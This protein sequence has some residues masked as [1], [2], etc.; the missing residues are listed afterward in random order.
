MRLRRRPG[1]VA[2]EQGQRKQ[3]PN[4]RKRSDERDSRE[5][6]YPRVAAALLEHEPAQVQEGR[7]E[8]GEVHDHGGVGTDA[9]GKCQHL[10]SEPH[11]VVEDE[12]GAHALDADSREAHERRR[13]IHPRACER[14]HGERGD[15]YRVERADEA[16]GEVVREEGGADAVREDEQAKAKA[17]IPVPG[18]AMQTTNTRPK[19]RAGRQFAA[20]ASKRRARLEGDCRRSPD[21]RVPLGMRAAESV[22][23]L[24]HRGR[25][26][27]AA[28]AATA[29]EL[30]QQ[31]R[32]AF[33][34]GPDA[35]IR[36]LHKGRQLAPDAPLIGLDGKVMVMS[37]SAASI[38]DLNAA[39][40]DPTLRG[41]DNEDRIAA[42]RK[43]EAEALQ[44]A[45]LA[46]G[47]SKVWRSAQD[48]R[49]R[50]S[51][52]EAV[53]WQNFGTRPGTSTPHQFAAR[54]L[55]D[56]MATDPGVVVC[57]SQRRGLREEPSPK[58]NHNP[59]LKPSPQM[60]RAR[61][62]VVGTLGEMDPI[63]DRLKLSLQQ[64][65]GDL[66][67]YNTNHGM[68]IDM[69]L[70]TDDLVGFMPYPA[71]AETLLHELC[72]NWVGPHNKLFWTLFAQMRVEYL[73]EHFRLAASGV[74]IDGQTTAALAGIRADCE[75]PKAI[76]AA[77]L[78]GIAQEVGLP[79]AHELEEAV[80]EHLALVQRE[81][82][83]AL[84]GRV[85]G[86]GVPPGQAA[87]AAEISALTLSA[88][89]GAPLSAPLVDPRA[90]AAAAAEARARGAGAEARGQ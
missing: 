82:G 2:G 13:V 52:I 15:Q 40:A 6:E 44:P 55:L 36:L 20:T 24:V 83:G 19:K 79:M 72:H 76:A 1:H 69:K 63:D 64:Q 62:L 86:G 71:L 74:L 73:H 43:S 14:G 21:T 42:I 66:L 31:A 87:P 78:R 45:A 53:G 32:T 5:Q 33:A 41:F 30:V 65:G 9:E 89:G 4:E 27:V 16:V 3:H 12:K 25:S 10:R 48:P 23:T 85:L 11:G 59:N 50:F 7:A 8:F 28:G 75:N 35:D 84:A 67:G 80:L 17:A 26:H 60:Q 70:R 54:E 29:G 18:Y 77:V 81:S 90:R 58:P 22:I 49:Y 47:K 68:R 57:V 38:A 39:R 61:E 88:E 37:A 34:L 56:K 51:R 46:E